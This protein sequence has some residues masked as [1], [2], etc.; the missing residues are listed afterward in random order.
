MNSFFS[1]L[2]KLLDDEN[3]STRAKN[4]ISNILKLRKDMWG[5]AV[6]V[7]SIPSALADSEQVRK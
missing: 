3:T 4:M 5:H 7:E 1:D 6:S 2:Q